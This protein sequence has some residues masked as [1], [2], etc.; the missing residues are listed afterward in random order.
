MS[1]NNKD[2][3]FPDLDKYKMNLFELT[4][5]RLSNL[6]NKEIENAFYDSALFLPTVGGYMISEKFN[7]SELF[8]VRLSNK[9]GKDEDLSLIQS[10]SYPPTS[11]CKNNGR[12]NLKY[13]SVFYCSDFATSAM[14]ESE[15]NINEEGYLS[16]WNYSSKRD[17]KFN[18][19]LS[20]KIPLRNNWSKLAVYYR[21]FIIQSY[22]SKKEEFHNQKIALREFITDKFMN[23]KQPYP[24]T[25]FLANEYLYGKEYVDFI[26]YPSAST[27]WNYTNFAFHPNTVDNHL[28]LKKVINFKV[29]EITSKGIIFII[30]K[31]GFIENDRIKWRKPIDEDKN[32]FTSIVD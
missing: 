10:Y 29:T 27:K 24:V 19:C 26:V 22:D 20:E 6:S 7:N 12:A 5:K 4:E 30:N 15:V 9:I 8:R 23:E 32:Y 31:V 13:K 25:S 21:D 2:I 18:M 1:N 3:S 28:E 14:R 11:A 17:L 16:I